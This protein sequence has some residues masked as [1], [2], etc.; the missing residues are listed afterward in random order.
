VM[1]EV[2][3]MTFLVIPWNINSVVIA[4]RTSR[5]QPSIALK[6]GDRTEQ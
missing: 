4:V 3:L 6:E 5:M 1:C 2:L